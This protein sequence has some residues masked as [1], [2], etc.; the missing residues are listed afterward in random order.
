MAGRS[1]VSKEPH[2]SVHREQDKQARTPR[3]RGGVRPL[4]SVLELF[5]GIAGL[6]AALLGIFAAAAVITVTITVISPPGEPPVQGPPTVQTDPA[7][8]VT[9]EEPDGGSDSDA[10][11]VSDAE[12]NC[13]DVPNPGQEDTNGA[14][15]GDA[16][17]E[18]DDNDGIPDDAPDNCRTVANPGQ[19]DIDGDG[20]GDACDE[21]EGED[22]SAD[23]A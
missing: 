6:V 23:G 17:D 20:Q 19:E 21:A 18:D 8:Q 16:C 1:P 22:S 11:G 5:S 14:G 3:R 13:P 12:D 7:R 9:P 15:R 4:K 2:M 10:D